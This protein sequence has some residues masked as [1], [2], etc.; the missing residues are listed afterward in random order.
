MPNKTARLP[1]NIRGGARPNR[2][3]FMCGEI[4][5]AEDLMDAVEEDE[6][7][8]MIMDT[9]M[10]MAGAVTDPT[11][12]LVSPTFSDGER[13]QSRQAAKTNHI[14]TTRNVEAVAR[15][16]ASTARTLPALNPTSEWIGGEWTG[17]FPINTS[18]ER[19]HPSVVE[20]GVHVLDFFAGITCAGLRILWPP[21]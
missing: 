7:T 10:A 3:I 4:T 13:F 9:V 2:C 21:V 18:V 15:L 5:F 14:D 19:F 12:M 16:L 11:P 8:P 20:K 1:V 17:A 6:E